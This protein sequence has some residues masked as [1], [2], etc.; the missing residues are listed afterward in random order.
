[1]D[2]QQARFNM[3]EQQIRPW[4][5]LNFDLLDALESI[6]REKFVQ[7]N[8]QGYA[9]ADISLRCPTAAGCW[10]PKSWHG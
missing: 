7:E 5:V 6:P 9:Y 8:Q 2:F 4:D 1:M 3:V 10:N